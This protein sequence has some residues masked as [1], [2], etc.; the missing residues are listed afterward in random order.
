MTL[1]VTRYDGSGD[2][3]D[4][5]VLAQR[6]AP[7]Y[8][9]CHLYG[10]RRVMQQAMGHDTPYLVA[11]DEATSVIEGVLP[12]VRVKSILFGHFVVSVPFVNYGGPIGTPRAVR[13]L[14][15]YASQLAD[16]GGA[17]ILELRSRFDLGQLQDFNVS[18]R[19]ITVLMDSSGGSEAL[20]KRLPSKLRSQ[21]RRPQKEG[22]SV[23]IGLDQAAPFYSVFARHMRDLGTPVMPWSFFQA[24]VSEFPDSA[25]FA[26]A[27]HGA[28]PV[29][30]GAGFSWGSGD[31]RE[32]E[33]TWASA[34]GEYNRISPNML[35]Y[36][37]LMKHVSD[38]GVNTFNFGRCTP[39]GNTHRFKTQWGTTDQPLWWYE[40]SASGATP[41]TE[42][43]AG[44][45]IATR[46]WK[47]V[48]LSVANVLGPRLVRLIPL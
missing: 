29:A 24:V 28:T 12:L 30:C 41:M 18:H 11:T 9:H 37:E 10:W 45:G 31:Y 5:F 39:G 26:V 19:K 33:I 44:A 48:P 46:L 43:N 47:H 13:A 25:L 1:T 34:L 3:W 21:I 16:A 27:Y 23:R 17:K 4:S 20:W 38:N 7:H 15:A 36:W 22:L 8:T 35:V 2:V 40:H 42:H 6:G 32:F 14:A